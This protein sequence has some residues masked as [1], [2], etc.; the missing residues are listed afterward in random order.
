MGLARL[1][2]DVKVLVVV[3]TSLA[4]DVVVKGVVLSATH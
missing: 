4:D 1:V 2:V 3:D